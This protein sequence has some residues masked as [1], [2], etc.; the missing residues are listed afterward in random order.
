MT[1]ASSAGASV[2][3]V[4]THGWSDAPASGGKVVY[5]GGC[6]CGAVRW[7]VRAE[8]NLVAWDC[9]CSK[10]AMTR[11]VHFIVP[12]DDFELAHDAEEHLREYRF[13]QQVARHRFCGRCGVQSFYHPRSNPD[14]IGVT[15]ACL[16]DPPPEDRVEVRRF[17][18]RNWDDTYQT[19]NI[20]ACSV[21]S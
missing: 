13:G 10:C 11:N 15:V 19:S 17:D 1:A 18:G 12:R 9:N 2:S 5:S 8:R 20:G 7:R 21:A 3:S 16:D 6:H 4:D 14:G